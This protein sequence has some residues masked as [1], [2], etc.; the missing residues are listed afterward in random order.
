MPVFALANAGVD[1]RNGLLDAIQNPIAIG[2][3]TALFLGNQ[4]GNPAI[5]WIM[6]RISLCSLPCA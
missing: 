3:A 5:T 2:I 6:L 4:I 1:M